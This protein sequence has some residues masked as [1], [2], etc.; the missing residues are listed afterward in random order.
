MPEIRPTLH[1]ISAFD[2]ANGTVISFSWTGAQSQKNR[3]TIRE[4]DTKRIVYD[5]TQK[6]MALK[7]R[8]HL[9]GYGE[10]NAAQEVPYA[11]AN[12]KR[13]LAS[14]YIYDVYGNESLP[15]KEVAF[16]C[17]ETPVFQFINFTNVGADNIAKVNVNS[18]YLSVRYSQPDG[19]VLNEYRFR[20][21]NN[22]GEELASSRM[23]YGSASDDTLQWTLGGITDT[24]KDKNGELNYEMAYKVVCEGTTVHGMYLRAE[25][26]FVVQKDTGGV[27]ALLTLQSLPDHTIAISSHFKIVNA[28]IDGEEKYIHDSDGEPF[29]LDLTE[30][31]LLSYFEGFTMNTPFAVTAIAKS[32]MPDTVLLTAS[33]NKGEKFTVKYCVKK[34][35]LSE[36]AYFLFECRRQSTDFILRSDYLPVSDTWYVIYL[37]YEQGYFTFKI[38]DPEDLDY[39]IPV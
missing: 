16:Y 26:R 6:T 14:V 27:G 15:S 38:Y 37:K 8:L 36:K 31:Q 3:I 17:F 33:N 28:N 39:I 21:Y 35:S 10:E 2:A 20:L 34:Y 22:T 18:V 11:L 12:G 23:F 32:C 29:A 7:H 19:E 1:K 25:Q 13:Y 30:G 4:Y 9:A 5:C 24:E